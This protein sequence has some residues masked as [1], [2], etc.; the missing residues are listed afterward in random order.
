MKEKTKVTRGSTK[1]NYKYRA[2]GHDVKMG[3]VVWGLKR[4]LF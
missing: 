2:K 1:D 3:E 4:M